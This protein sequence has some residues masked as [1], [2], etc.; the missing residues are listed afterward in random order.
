MSRM[1]ILNSVV[2]AVAILATAVIL[3]GSGEFISVAI[4]LLLGAFA[5]G[6]IIQRRW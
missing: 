2:W 1:L 4:V 3:K 6:E 5:S